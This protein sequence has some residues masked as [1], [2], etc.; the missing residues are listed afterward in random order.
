LIFAHTS[1][2]RRRSGP[3]LAIVVESIF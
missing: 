1:A 2:V 3:P